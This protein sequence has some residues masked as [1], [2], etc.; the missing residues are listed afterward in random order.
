MGDENVAVV[1]RIFREFARRE[2]KT[3]FEVYDPEIVWDTREVFDGSSDLR[4]MTHGKE[5]VRAWWRQWLEAWEAIEFVSAEH[6]PH[7]NQVVS[8]WHQR[9]RGRGSGAVVDM[10]SA[11]VWTFQ[12]GLIVRAAVFSSGEDARRAAGLPV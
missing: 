4:G 3:A 8:I 7:G 1:E 5:G 12:N 11:I 9:N 6:I 2:S 10:D